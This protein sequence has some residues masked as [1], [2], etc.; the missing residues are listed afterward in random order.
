MRRGEGYCAAGHGKTEEEAFRDTF[1][2]YETLT[3]WKETWEEADFRY[4]DS[5]NF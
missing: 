1:L 5:C 3:A 4:I 2:Q